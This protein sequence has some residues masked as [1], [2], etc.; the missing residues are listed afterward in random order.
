LRASSESVSGNT[1][2]IGHSKKEKMLFLENHIIE[3]TATFPE[4]S[5]VNV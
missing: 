1:Y 4:L 3:R 2:R 5:F